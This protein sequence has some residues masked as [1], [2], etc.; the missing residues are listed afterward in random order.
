MH[1]MSFML[2]KILHKIMSFTW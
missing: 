1:I 2:Y